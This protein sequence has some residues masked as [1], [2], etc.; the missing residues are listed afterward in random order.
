M[1]SSPAVGKKEQKIFFST[2]QSD[3]SVTTDTHL[4][5]RTPERTSERERK[6]KKVS[7]WKEDSLS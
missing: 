6:K 2:F 4:S 3:D 1:G 5:V 7:K